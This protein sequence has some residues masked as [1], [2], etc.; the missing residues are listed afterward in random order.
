MSLTKLNSYRSYIWSHR[1]RSSWQPTNC[2]FKRAVKCV[3]LKTGPKVI[4]HVFNVLEPLE[5]GCLIGLDFLKKH[6][7]DSMISKDVLRLDDD[8]QVPLYHREI[9]DETASVYRVVVSE[10]VSV[11]VGHSLIVPA[12]I[13]D[14]KQSHHETEAIFNLNN[15]FDEQKRQW[16]QT[17]CLISPSKQYP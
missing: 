2:Q 9:D 12:L 5:A 4:E 13:L 17:F 6:K 15:R 11:T 7:C 10:T 14:W 1:N 3:L 16:L 8:T